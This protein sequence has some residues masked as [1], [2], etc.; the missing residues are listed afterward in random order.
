MR[1]RRLLALAGA[2]FLL[3][4][5]TPARAAS[6]VFDG[7]PVDPS[8]SAPYEILPGQPLV[9]AGLDGRVGT[10][11]DVVHPTVIGDIDLAVRLGAVPA[12]AEI[13]GS[14]ASRGAVVT[15]TAG[16]RGVA[17]AIPFH[18]YLSDG[19]VA[20][21]RPSGN[22]LAAADM[23]GLPAIVTLFA[24]RDG[25]G[26]IGPA[27]KDPKR[28]VRALAEL[29]PIG[30]EV[31]L[32]DASGRAEGTIVAAVGGPPSRGGITVVATASA[33]TGP[34][35][36]AIL[37]GAVPTG[38]G[39]TTAQPFLPERDPARIF[40]DVG[41]LAVDETLNPRLR[42]AA[43]PDPQGVLSLALRTKGASPTTDTARAV[44]GPAVCA[45]LVEPARG[46]GL[47]SEP[48]SLTLGTLGSAGRVKLVVVAVDRFGNPTD[49]IP[50]LT[51]RLVTNAPIALTPDA[52]A[53]PAS[54]PV[55]VAKATGA[56]VTV[57]ATG[58]GSGILRVLVNGALCQSLGVSTHPERNSGGADATVAL[59]G[60][61]DYRS[62]AE[63]AA[64]ATDRDDDGRITITVADGIYRE[65]V[66]VTRD[67]EILGAGHGRSIVDARGLGTT[68]TLASPAALVRGVTASG[69]TTG[70]AVTVP[71]AVAG[72]DAR[73]NVGDGIALATSG[74]VATACVARENGGAGFRLTAAGT[75]AANTAIDNAG[76]GFASVATAPGVV[77]DGNVA[78]LNGLEGILVVEASAPLIVDNAIGGNYGEGISLEDSAG[79][80]VAGNRAAGNDGD[81]LS[82]NQS[83]GA[84]VDGNDLT[85]NHGYGLRID[86]TTADYDAAAGT[87]DA[88]GTNDVSD[89]RK[90]AIDVR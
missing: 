7:D 23:V 30:T 52:D 32:F 81:G 4:G 54:E 56:K 27:G 69:G 71:M 3:F 11:D 50:G 40:T 73:G 46:R 28:D 9:T 34:Y 19:A 53:T 22:L 82:L 29:E 5:G 76:P 20:S 36:P 14:A 18:V 37:E 47:P 24:D 80:T 58:A 15:A 17:V 72:L 48:P 43:I 87:Q 77:I 26:W 61:A 57:Q 6:V 70:I 64:A 1:T 55:V 21:G 60:R 66:L 67:L 83:D 16:L 78:T 25:D 45:R 31:A 51:A 86:R 65:N 74:V 38:P 68:L 62:L 85:R 75:V 89:N 79:G 84:L 8:T 12:G 10:A 49:P 33:L 88:P 39:I 41:P 13:P 59:K 63:A 42:A 90:G 44:A 35:D 2:A